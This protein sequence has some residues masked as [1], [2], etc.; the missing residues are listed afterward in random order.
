MHKRKF[1]A[2]S[3]VENG[4]DKTP[5]EK[6]TATFKVSNFGRV[7]SMN[8]IKSY[9]RRTDE[10]YMVVG[11]NNRKTMKVHNLVALA[12]IGQKPSS[13]HT[14]DHLNN[15]HNDNRE[16]NLVWATASEQVR[17]SYHRNLN[18]AP[19]G[20]KTS[21]PVQYRSNAEEEWS[22]PLTSVTE[23]G[24][25]F[26]I[27]R[28]SISSACGKPTR[29]AGGFEWRFV[30]TLS[31]FDGEVW[32]DFILSEHGEIGQVVQKN[33]SKSTKNLRVSNFGRVISLKNVISTGA[34]TRGGYKRVNVRGTKY[35]VHDLVARLF[36][37]PP[38][39]SKHTVN[40]LDMNKEN[41][42]ASNLQWATQSEQVL[43][44]FQCNKNR[45]SNAPA[46]SKP[47][48]GRKVGDNEWISYNS[49]CSA[50]R[51]LSLSQQ[52]VNACCL[53]KRNTTGGYEF[54][55][56]KTD[57]GTSLS[58]EKWKQITIKFSH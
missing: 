18:R 48:I 51:I 20:V 55:Y 43:H 49:T 27:N 32:K 17:N 3:V 21:K 42:A 26:N 40:H 57:S 25:K 39:S 45:R 36:I 8:G 58:G 56:K 50:A 1:S 15:I 28:A 30:D 54:E 10:G 52:N 46:R 4:E 34:G 9:G 2:W 35:R 37:G 29:R 6:T 19:C 5:D 31:S 13:S 53:K 14:I 12:F 16:E 44:S 7:E 41:N 33:E 11:G 22:L 24:L 47:L 38:P 23:A